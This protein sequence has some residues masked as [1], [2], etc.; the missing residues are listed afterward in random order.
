MAFFAKHKELHDLNRVVT[1]SNPNVG[2]SGLQEKMWAFLAGDN[3][4]VSGITFSL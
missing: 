4:E 3:E 2:E 1:T